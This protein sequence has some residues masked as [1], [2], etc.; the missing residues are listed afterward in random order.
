MDLQQYL[1]KEKSTTR[2]AIIFTNYRK[3]L[4]IQFGVKI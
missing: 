2:H 4:Y 1:L 3:F